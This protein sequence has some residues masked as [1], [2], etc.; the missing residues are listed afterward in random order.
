MNEL[1]RRWL[2]WREDIKREAAKGHLIQLDVAVDPFVLE[3]TI[4][5]AEV[6]LTRQEQPRRLGATVLSYVADAFILGTYLLIA[7]A[8]W[9]VWWFHLANALGCVPLLVIEYRQR[10]YPVMPLTASFGV[11]GWL[12]LL[13]VSV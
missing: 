13:G 10:A 1:R 11:I 12:G 9:S 4:E 8:G 6:E 5:L 2:L 7:V 3:R